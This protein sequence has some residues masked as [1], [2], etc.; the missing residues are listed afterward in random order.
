VEERRRTVELSPELIQAYAVTFIPRFDM[1]PVQVE[2]GRYAKRERPLTPKL[3]E[4]HL[5]GSVTLGAYALDPDSQAQW[6]CLDA[7]FDEQFAG[8]KALARSLAAEGVTAYV[9]PSRRGGHLWLFTPKLPGAEARRFAR[10]L[11][12]DHQLPA[13]M[14]VY[15]KQ[16]RLVTGPGSLVRLPLGIHR[17]SNR[18]Y[19]FVTMD[20]Q[21]LAPTIRE[22]IA[23][24][25]DPVRV[26]QRFID[27]V[28]ALAPEAKPVFPTPRF[29]Q[30]QP[31]SGAA[32][33]EAL[34]SRISVADFV[35]QFVELDVQGRGLCPFHD[36]HAQSFQVNETGNYWYCYAGCGGGSLIDFWAHWR[37]THGQSPDFK[38]TVTA[39]ANMLL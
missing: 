30:L 4:A 32:L 2:S 22:Q 33:S 28:L 38:E 36:D 11:V 35:R 5:R 29:H 20:G 15:P 37:S 10:Q 6:V 13:S 23:L 8:L 7:D 12:A 24:L 31:G 19:H 14:E 21:P 34:K 1:F 17:K 18:R 3:V 16:D 9:E 25:V 27:Q 26:P 39:L